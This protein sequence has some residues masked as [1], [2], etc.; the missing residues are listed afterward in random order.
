MYPFGRCQLRYKI[1]SF[2]H[3]LY[4]FVLAKIFWLTSEVVGL[5]YIRY[6]YDW[7]M[8]EMAAYIAVT[9]F[10]GKIDRNSPL[11]LNFSSAECLPGIKKA[12]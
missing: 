9:G 4:N 5:Q 10:I 1:H 12:G 6:F 3:C 11:G 8:P 2:P 7:K